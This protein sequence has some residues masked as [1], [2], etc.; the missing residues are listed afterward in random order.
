MVVK[1]ENQNEIVAGYNEKRRVY[2][3]TKYAEKIKEVEQLICHNEFNAAEVLLEG[4]P[5]KTTLL[6]GLYEKLQDKPFYSVL[7]KCIKG[8]VSGDYTELKAFLSFGVHVAIECENGKDEYRFLLKT[9]LQTI[10]ELQ[11]SKDLSYE[12]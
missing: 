5:D 1:M 9:I 12:V 10:Q 6:K 11:I 3:G 2:Q 8:E 7:K 4:L